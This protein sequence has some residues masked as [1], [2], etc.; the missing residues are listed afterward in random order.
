MRTLTNEYGHIIFVP[1]S[2]TERRGMVT[3]QNLFDEENG[4]PSS[5]RAKYEKQ[6]WAFVAGLLVG[7][8]RADIGALTCHD[9][10]TKL[11]P[12]GLF[13][14]PNAIYRIIHAMKRPYHSINHAIRAHGQSCLEVIQLMGGIR[15]FTV[16]TTIGEVTYPTQ[17]Y[18][19]GEL[20]DEVVRLRRA[21]APII[22][23][24]P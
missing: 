2:I 22:Q 1:E 23:A 12:H 4:I 17:A 16:A 6:N 14:K 10:S 11:E 24:K 9:I 18:Y 8:D 15:E 3:G 7:R 13:I 5:Q 20:H 21:L 19:L